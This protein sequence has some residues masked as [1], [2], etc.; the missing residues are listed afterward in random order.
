MGALL[1][2]NYWVN[3]SEGTWENGLC[4]GPKKASICEGKEYI[5]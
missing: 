3:K 5:L 1:N 4:P 2:I